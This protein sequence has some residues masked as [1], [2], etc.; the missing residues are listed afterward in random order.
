MTITHVFF[1][2]HKK[3]NVEKCT[4]RGK[5]ILELKQM[6]LRVFVSIYHLLPNKTE[7]DYREFSSQLVHCSLPMWNNSWR[8]IKKSVNRSTGTLIFSVAVSINTS[9]ISI[10]SIYIMVQLNPTVGTPGDCKAIYSWGGELYQRPCLITLGVNTHY[11]CYVLQCPFLAVNW[12]T[13]G[14]F[15]TY[16]TEYPDGG[17]IEK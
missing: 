14:L 17:E 7:Q 15:I 5:I 4:S 3:S 13:K 10:I 11:Q 1:F 8:L 6:H 16:F 2:I 12:T 9:Y